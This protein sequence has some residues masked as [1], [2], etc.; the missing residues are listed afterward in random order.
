ML[1][2]DFFV[3]QCRKACAGVK[4]IVLTIQHSKLNN[5]QINLTVIR[6]D[7]QIV[8]VYCRVFDVYQACDMYT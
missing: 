5:L 4:Y 2:D 1:P 7:C 6:H 3:K 8:D